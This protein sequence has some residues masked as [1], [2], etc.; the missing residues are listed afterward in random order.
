MR[1]Q[2]TVRF[3]YGE[4]V[5]LHPTEALALEDARR[6][7]DAEFVRLGCEPMRASGKLLFADKLLAIADAAAA[8]GFADANWAQAYARAALGALGRESLRV[9]LEDNTVGH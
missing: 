4:E 7:L 9:N 8:A 1:H 6:W 5:V 2:V 3:A